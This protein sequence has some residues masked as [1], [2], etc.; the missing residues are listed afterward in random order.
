MILNRKIYHELLKWK[1][2]SDGTTA[3]LIEGARRIGKSFITEEFAKNEYKSY[4]ILDFS[5]KNKEIESVFLENQ[6]DLDIFFNRLQIIYG[7]KLY[8][9][10][11]IIIFDEVQLFPLARQM[12]KHLVKDGRYDYIETG[13]LLS[14]KTNVQDIVIPSEEES[15]RMNPLDFEEFLWAIGDNI[16]YDL[17]QDFYNKKKQLGNSVHETIMKL[18]TEYILVGGM[19]QA[20]LEYIKTKDFESVERIKRNI[21]KLYR[22]DIVKF[23]SG[24][25][26]SVLSVFDNIPTELSKSYKRF[27]LSSIDKNAR[28]RNYEDSFIWLDEA[29]IVNVCFN[30]LDPNV[31]LRMNLSNRALKLYMA[32]TG[33]LISHALK[34][35]SYIDS[36]IYKSLLFNKLSINKGMFAENVV[37]Q[38]LVSKGYDLFFYINNDNVNREN[39]MEVDFLISNGNKVIPIEVKSG[40]YRSHLSI[41][42]F[43]TKYS[44]RVDKKI[45]LHTKD[46]SVK[47]DTIY[48]PLYMAGL[49]WLKSNSRK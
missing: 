9:R 22:N 45:V 38:M 47:G 14:L 34:N 17:M 1:S 10:E 42:R 32:D 36:E 44:K 35:K 27:N 40:N 5:R 41:D 11:S 43:K 37:A 8:E 15:I 19:P 12:I 31:G 13:S 24:Y 16:T 49:I 25:E 3:L 7:T 39:N 30:S 20:V 2:S 28:F 6:L 21:L 4:I 18:F 33:L 26:N 23:A 46:L 29:E 48:L